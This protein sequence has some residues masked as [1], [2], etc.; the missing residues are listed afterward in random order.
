MINSDDNSSLVGDGFASALTG[1]LSSNGFVRLNVRAR[2]HVN[3]VNRRGREGGKYQLNVTVF[4]DEKNFPHN[5]GDG[6]AVDVGDGVAVSTSGGG[7]G[8]GNE[9]IGRSQQNP[10]L[11]NAREG[12]WQV[13]RNVA[14]CRWYDPPTTYGFEFQALDDTLFT[15]ILDFPFDDDNRFTVSVG[16]SILGEFSP[17]QNVD[18]VS[19]LGFGVPNFKITGIDSL[20]GSTEETAFPIQ[21]A[22]N[23]RRGS[24]KMRPISPGTSPQSTPES[25]SALGLFVL[26]A[27]GII[28][29]MKIRFEK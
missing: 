13:F 7:G 22:F 25:T 4:N 11:P 29:A 9:G 2:N 18:F 17:G 19:L 28:K 10:I 12:N 24:F 6:V 15:E 16:D 26:G 3:A 5:A 8:V 23:D 20:F 14:G 27:W 1:N 21:L